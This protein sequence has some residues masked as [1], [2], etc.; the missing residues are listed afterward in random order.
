MEKNFLLFTTT[1]RSKSSVSET[2]RVLNGIVETVNGQGLLVVAK[3]NWHIEKVGLSFLLQSYFCHDEKE[4]CILCSG[5]GE[6]S[7]SMR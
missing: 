6:G 3:L 2:Y 7:R 1:T 4:L 5:F